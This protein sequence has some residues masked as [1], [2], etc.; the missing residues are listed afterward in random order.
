MQH[1]RKTWANLQKFRDSN[2]ILKLQ[3][4]EN[5]I[6]FIGDSI[7]AGWK[8]HALF[9]ENTQY[10]N[11]GVNGQTTSQI[12]RRFKTDVI[13]LQPKFVLI[14]VGT[15]DVAENNGPITLEEI[16]TNFQSMVVIAQEHKVNVILGS[17][18]P[19]SHYYWN[20]NIAEPLIKISAINN[21]LS[22]LANNSTVFFLDFYTDLLENS[23]MNTNYSADGVHPNLDG[24]TVMT[25]IFQKDKF[26]NF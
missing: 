16:Q 12:L 8:H 5:R 22:S 20:K 13:A 23:A 21:F 24:Y 1:F 15:N 4:D 2:E 11:R 19:A 3:F 18:L 26:L 10:I 14:L 7:I 25:K 9:Q 17:I 6:V